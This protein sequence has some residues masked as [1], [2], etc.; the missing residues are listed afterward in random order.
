MVNNF[1]GFCVYMPDSKKKIKILFLCTS[2]SSRSQMAQGWANHLKGN[3]IEAYSAGVKPGSI[4]KKAIAAMQEAGVD[5]SAQRSKNVNELKGVDFDY[6]ITVCDYAK[7]QCPVFP[8]DAKL[9][10]KSFEDPSEVC[11]TEQ[12]KMEKYREIRDLIKDFVTGMPEN[13]IKLGA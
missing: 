10:H 3:I 9:I 7:E 13:I 11:G 4:S 5:I 2:N 8:K 6:V 12:E 1:L